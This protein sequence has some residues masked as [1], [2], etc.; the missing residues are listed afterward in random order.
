[1]MNFLFSIQKKVPELRLHNM[2]I[3]HH[4]TIGPTILQHMKF[5]IQIV[6]ITPMIPTVKL[7]KTEL[8]ITKT[9]ALEVITAQV[10]VEILCP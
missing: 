9:T 8:I 3:V 7:I 6:L 1:M 10:V 4:K 2:E 5:L